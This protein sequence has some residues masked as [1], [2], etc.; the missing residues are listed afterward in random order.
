MAK[1]GAPESAASHIVSNVQWRGKR[2]LNPSSSAALKAPPLEELPCIKIDLQMI[3]IALITWDHMPLPQG[4]FMPLV[5]AF[6]IVTLIRWQNPMT[7]R[8]MPD[9]LIRRASRRVGIGE[10]QSTGHA[11]SHDCGALL[12]SVQCKHSR[13]KRHVAQA[14]AHNVVWRTLDFLHI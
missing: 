7:L 11:V 8:H 3:I 12:H 2:S 14:V 10:A 5:F 1:E 6:I 9:S 4:Y 13:A